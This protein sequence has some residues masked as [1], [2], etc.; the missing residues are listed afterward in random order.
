MTFKELLS[1]MAPPQKPIDSGAG[2]AWPEIKSG[3]PFPSDYIE[4]I[5][6]YGSGRIADFIVVFNPF[7]NEQDI[8]FFEQFKLILGDLDELNKSD[9][10]YYT[11]PVFS[12]S[13]GL[14]PI[15]VTDNGDYIFWAAKSGEHSDLWRV[16]IVAARS[17]EVE[18]L[19][20]G[21]VSTLA[22]LLAGT[23]KPTSFPSSF[24]KGVTR[25]DPI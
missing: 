5:N 3:L 1:I 16:A 14:I 21:L 7:S 2:K 20:T 6:A 8:N 24:A 9:P 22:G 25:F 11:Y 10:D 18:Y 15:G 13:G 12:M 23:I 17:P 4:F 19:N